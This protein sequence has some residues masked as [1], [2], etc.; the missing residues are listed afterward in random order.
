MLDQ[1][2]VHMP[3]KMLSDNQ[4]ELFEEIAKNGTL[5]FE[6]GPQGIDANIV[7]TFSVRRCGNED[8]LEMGDGTNHVHIDWKRI[9]SVK[10]GSYQNE[11]MLTFMDGEEV[12]FRLYKIGGH[13]S[14]AVKALIGDLLDQKYQAD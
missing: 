9:K 5:V 4:K 8:R 13:W 10:A 3:S 2:G 12:L 6:T 7:G 11:G 14:S 1:S